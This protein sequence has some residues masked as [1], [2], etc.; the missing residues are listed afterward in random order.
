[1]QA[2][3]IHSTIKYLHS[4]SVSTPLYYPFIWKTK[5]SSMFKETLIAWLQGGHTRINWIWTKYCCNLSKQKEKL[6]P[7]PVVTRLGKCVVCDSVYILRCTQVSLIVV[8]WIILVLH[9]LSGTC[10]AYVID[11]CKNAY[12][13]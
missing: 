2:N 11:N 4:F 9:D 12:D 8:M 3:K 10:G 7:M 13:F 6:G 5:K 1:M